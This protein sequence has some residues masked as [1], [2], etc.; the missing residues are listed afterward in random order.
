MTDHST[1]TVDREIDDLFLQARGLVLVR[2]LLTERGASQAD[3]DA[4]ARELERVRER[5]VNLVTAA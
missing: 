2:P 5:L 3:L 1:T 4:H